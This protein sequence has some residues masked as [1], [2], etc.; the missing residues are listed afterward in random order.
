MKKVLML[1][2]VLCLGFSGLTGVANGWQIA[3][4]AEAGLFGADW[5]TGPFD[6]PFV[7]LDA[8]GS[9]LIGTAND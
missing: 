6:P 5:A 4:E 9:Q 7:R 3:F 1:V 8:S 2:M